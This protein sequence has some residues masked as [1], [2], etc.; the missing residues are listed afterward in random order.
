MLSL[1]NR[2]FNGEEGWGTEIQSIMFKLQ[3]D[4]SPIFLKGFN[5]LDELLDLKA[6]GEK[7]GTG[8]VE[9]TKKEKWTKCIGLLEEAVSVTLEKGQRDTAK[10]QL[11]LEALARAYIETLQ[12]R[13]A[14]VTWSMLQP[15]TKHLSTVKGE[16]LQKA[17]DIR[18]LEGLFLDVCVA[19][20]RKDWKHIRNLL[21]SDWK[22]FVQAG[23]RTNFTDRIMASLELME[24][25]S[26]C[27]D[28]KS[29]YFY[30]QAEV[31]EIARVLDDEWKIEFQDPLIRILQGSTPQ[32]SPERLED[33]LV[34]KLGVLCGECLEPLGEYSEKF[35]AEMPL[36][37]YPRRI[38]KNMEDYLEDDLKD[39]K[40]MLT[41]I[42]RFPWFVWCKPYEWREL[43]EGVDKRVYPAELWFAAL[44][45]WLT[46]QTPD[47]DLFVHFMGRSA[48]GEN[49]MIY[50]ARG[51][52]LVDR[53][54]KISSEAQALLA[55]ASIKKCAQKIARM[56]KWLEDH[57]LVHHDLKP[58]NL[59]VTILS[60]DRLAD[61]LRLC[62]FGSMK[63]VG[64]MSPHEGTEG[65]RWPEGENE[66][67]QVKHDLYSFKVT[68]E[69]ITELAA[70]DCIPPFVSEIS[71]AFS[72]DDINTDGKL[73]F[74]D[75]LKI[76]EK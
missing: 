30:S 63:L 47:S 38:T 36:L 4:A 8:E 71:E 24:I 50:F 66:P 6:K 70:I 72:K 14:K 15:K 12:F 46:Y 33:L 57:G 27:F 49:P 65:Y 51:N 43:N 28:S 48:P 22:I 42:Q 21:D 69:K 11:R 44:L 56:M 37:E 9:G 5:L 10:G 40:D 60:P 20:E 7:K 76:L 61:G 54:C 39:S 34:Q 73:G 19:R 23:S 41:E 58:G 25:E 3:K 53:N 52:E 16:D 13:S 32:Y 68:I 17:E 64:D 1:E 2:F 75:I 31:K 62:D 55:G 67:S 45:H 35:L 29:L 59:I 74:S 26:N 18:K